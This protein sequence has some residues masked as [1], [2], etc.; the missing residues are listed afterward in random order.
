MIAVVAQSTTDEI[1][2]QSIFVHLQMSSVCC[3]A[4]LRQTNSPADKNRTLIIAIFLYIDFKDVKTY[5]FIFSDF[6][7][8]ISQNTG[9]DDFTFRSS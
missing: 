7:H 6:H 1:I 4:G 8:V 3:S 2:H 9:H 5:L